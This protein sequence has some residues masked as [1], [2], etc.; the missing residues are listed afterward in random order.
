MPSTYD[1]DVRI[2]LRVTVNDD[3]VIDRVVQNKDGDGVPQPIGSGGWQ[4]KLYSLSTPEQVITMLAYN[5][6]VNGVEDISRLD[7]WGDLDY[8]AVD[9]KIEDFD[10]EYFKDVTG[11]E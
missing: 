5:A 10:V 7:G 6:T 11:Q 4:D 2:S 1:V 8:E 9:F 3:D